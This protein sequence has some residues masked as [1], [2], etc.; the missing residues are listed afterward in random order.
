MEKDEMYDIIHS[1]FFLA[2][3]YAHFHTIGIGE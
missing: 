2:W 1:S 3:F